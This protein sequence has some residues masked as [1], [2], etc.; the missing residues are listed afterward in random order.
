MKIIV[1][2][3]GGDNSPE[4]TLTGVLEALDECSA[5]FALVGDMEKIG[6]IAAEKEIDLNNKRFETY[7]VKTVIEMTDNPLC[8]VRAKKD[9]SMSV[10][11]RLLADGNGDAVVSAGN[12]GALFTGASVI[13]RK[14]RGVKRP[15]IGSIM[16]FSSPVLLLDSGANLEVNDENLEQFGIMGSVYMKNC[17]GLSAPRVGLLNNGTE[18]CKGKEL[19]ID[20]YKRLSSSDKLNFVGNVEAGM[21]PFNACDIVVTDGFTGNILLKTCEGMGKLMGN[22]LKNIFYES[23]LTKLSGLIVKKGIMQL[24]QRYD[25][26]EYGGAPILGISKPVIKAHGSSNSKAFK[27]A[28]LQAIT[29]AESEVFGEIAKAIKS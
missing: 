19:Q 26:T 2:L 24:K 18:P 6:L 23:N 14:H 13:V 28:I 29:V 5:D 7:N 21:L 16:P 9:S 4:A 8:V 3:M 27:N 20:S 1:D 22:E 12:S 11:L 25:T 17:Y 10:A 15:A